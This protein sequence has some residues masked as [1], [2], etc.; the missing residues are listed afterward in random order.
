M[1]R[2]FAGLTAFALAAAL[3]LAACGGSKESKS[4]K[5][6]SGSAP[7]ETVTGSVSSVVSE[8]SSAQ[9]EVPSSSA[10]QA[11]SSAPAETKLAGD[12]FSVKGTVLTLGMKITDS[13]LSPLGKP[14]SKEEAESCIGEGKDT[15]YYYDGFTLYT[16]MKGKDSILYEAEITSAGIPLSTGAKVGMKFDEVRA[17]YTTADAP[18]EMGEGIEYGLDENRYYHGF[19]KTDGGDTVQRVEIG[20]TSPADN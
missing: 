15:I 16:F 11:V 12:Q 2:K 3:L 1:K 13:V 7:S 20:L 17:L 14:K 9:S 19:F 8:E 10:P 4:K 6:E 5:T 18:V